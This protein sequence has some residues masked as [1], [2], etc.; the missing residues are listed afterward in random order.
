MN[1][2]AREQ[3]SPDLWLGVCSDLLLYSYGTFAK[4]AQ[5]IQIHVRFAFIL[6]LHLFNTMSKQMQH[7]AH[8]FFVWHNWHLQDVLHPSV[9]FSHAEP[10]TICVIHISGPRW[11]K[12]TK[13]RD[14]CK[15]VCGC[16]KNKILRAQ[17]HTNTLHPYNVLPKGGWIIGFVCGTL[18][19]FTM[20]NDKWFYC[21]IQWDIQ[22]FR[23]SV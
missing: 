18:E 12:R 14:E 11:S 10:W 20:C 23:P 21:K 17:T 15:S 19:V 13:R 1:K 5:T 7:H 2:E 4:P 8:S 9:H 22:L 16:Y 3:D 6:L